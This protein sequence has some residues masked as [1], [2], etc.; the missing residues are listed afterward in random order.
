MS[1]D[2]N[3]NLLSGR[4]RSYV[5]NAS[6]SPTQINSTLFAYDGVGERLKQASAGSTSIYPLG[7]DYEITNGLVTKYLPSMALACWPSVLRAPTDR[8]HGSPAPNGAARF[9]SGYDAVPVCRVYSRTHVPDA[10]KNQPWNLMG[11][12]NRAVHNSVHGWSPH[13]FNWWERGWYGSPGWFKVLA[14]SSSGRGVNAGYG[15]TGE[16]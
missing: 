15:I 13:Q 16:W 4:G 8:L 12:P 6:D 9:S 14:L 10:I 11:L 3:G 5:W 7:D 1:Y 2:L